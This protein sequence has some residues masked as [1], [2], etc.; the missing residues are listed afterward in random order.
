MRQL[1]KK[2]HQKWNIIVSVTICGISYRGIISDLTF[3]RKLLYNKYQ[4]C[5]EK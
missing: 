5:G 4:K 3:K 2:I 1:F